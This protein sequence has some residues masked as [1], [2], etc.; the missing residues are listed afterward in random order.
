MAAAARNLAGAEE[1]KRE[2]ERLRDR[3]KAGMP[4]EEPPEGAALDEAEQVLARLRATLADLHGEKVRE[5][6]TAATAGDRERALR[7][8]ETERGWAPPGWLA[9][10]VGLV[11]AALLAAAGW[12]A[13]EGDTSGAGAMLVVSLLAAALAVAVTRLKKRSDADDL[14]RQEVLSA[15]E[16]EL[17]KATANLGA[18]RAEVRR[19]TD[20]LAEDARALGLLDHPS[21]QAVEER[22]VELSRRREERRRFDETQARLEEQRRTCGAPKTGSDAKQER[23]AKRERRRRRNRQP[24][25]SGRREVASPR[26]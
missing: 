7:S 2:A 13:V 25:Q 6:A 14:R 8:M 3:I 19:L 21:A 10:A 18:H 9:P 15:L 26:A 24:G 16:A 4:E 12:R 23:L 1:K 17:E 22:A 5:E 20:V 11:A